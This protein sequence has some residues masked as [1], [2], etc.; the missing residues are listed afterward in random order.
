[1][2]CVV[3][4]S[5]HENDVVVRQFGKELLVVIPSTH[6][7]DRAGREFHKVS[8]SCDVCHL[9]TSGYD[10]LRKQR[11][12]VEHRMQLDSSLGAGVMSLLISRQ[13]PLLGR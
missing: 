6:H 7:N 5:R 13:A 4:E 8:G 3:F 2:D 1:M 12:I 11:I 9:A 10:D